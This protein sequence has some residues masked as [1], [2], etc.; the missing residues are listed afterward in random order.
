[1]Q[2]HQL[3]LAIFGA[4]LSL[5]SCTSEAPKEAPTTANESSTETVP[6]PTAPSVNL[7]AID[8]FRAEVESLQIP[9]VEVSTA[10]LREK[11]KQKWSKLHFYAQNGSILK[12]KTYPHPAISKRT[13]E[14][15]V[16]DNQLVLVVIEDNGEG[17]KG[18]P[19]A[20]L[21]KLYY[22]NKGQLAKEVRNND[23][24]EYTVKQSDAEEL[25]AEF[26]EYLAVFKMQEQ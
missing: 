21:D 3:I 5:F 2:Q 9:P 1:M 20:E 16:K 6:E 12:I 23:K 4:I 7:E 24:A 25:L 22:F 19:K 17:P 11:I 15:Y 14:F 13:E 26:K 10:E 18:K 8:K